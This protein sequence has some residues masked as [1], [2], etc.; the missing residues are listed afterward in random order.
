MFWKKWKKVIDISEDLKASHKV[1]FCRSHG[2][3]VNVD[4]SCSISR[5][6]N[7]YLKVEVQMYNHN[8]MFIKKKQFMLSRI[9]S[10][11][12]ITMKIS[13]SCITCLITNKYVKSTDPKISLN[14]LKQERKTNCLL[15]KI[16]LKAYNCKLFKYCV[17]ELLSQSS[18]MLFIE[19]DE[20]QLSQVK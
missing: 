5:N 2:I 8:I 16:Y 14:W 6:K 7:K 10:W 1:W 20:I 9:K 11:H 3:V 4:L 13:K 19:F 12:K 17:L 18:Y 15:N